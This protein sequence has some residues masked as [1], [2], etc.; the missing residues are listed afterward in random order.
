MSRVSAITEGRESSAGGRLPTPATRLSALDASFLE[1]ESPAAHMHVGWVARFG[2]R[3]GRRSPTFAALQEHIAGRLPVAPRYRQRLVSVPWA[4]HDPLWIDDPEFRIERHVLAAGSSDVREVT[5]DVMS[6]PLARDRALWEMWIADDVEGDGF[7]LVGKAHH[8]MVD[9]LAAVELGMLLLDPVRDVAPRTPDPWRADPAPAPAGLL[10]NAVIDRVGEQVRMVGDLLRLSR[11]PRRLLSL[12]SGAI[13]LGRALTHSLLPVARPSALNTPSSA[14]RHLA[15]VR[16][17]LEDLKR[18][19]AHHRTTVNDVML[20][21]V[22]GGLRGFLAERGD[23]TDSL[24]AMVPVSVRTEAAREELGNRI[25]FMF[26]ELPCAEPDPLARLMAIHRATA[27]SKSTGEPEGSDIAL[28][29]LGHA[30]HTLQRLASHLV[31]SPR[32]FN[33]VVSNIP[34][35]PQALYMLGCELEAV[36]PIVPLAEGHALSIG[37]TTIHGQACFGLYADH[38][39]LPDVD[40]LAHHLD[41][42]LDELV[43]LS[44]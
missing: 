25:A 18:I 44:P 36:Y 8:C 2:R 23:A 28:R 38:Q 3:P 17:P 10:G 39:A 12:P 7:S 42:A 6:R 19:K 5:D 11:S 30:P 20:A 27:Q 9:G 35:P 41:A 15:T 24:K 34:G 22:A 14:A 13:R 21:A 1:V 43:D 29:G 33:L 4:V 16:R 37:M 26:T 32:S 40:R 31:A